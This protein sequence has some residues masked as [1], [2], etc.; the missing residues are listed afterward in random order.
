MQV[1]FSKIIWTDAFTNTKEVQVQRLLL[2]SSH[3][4]TGKEHNFLC[5]TEA[6]F[7]SGRLDVFDN[8]NSFE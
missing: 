1:K 8:K 3:E 4:V 5:G 7:L 2:C 6:F